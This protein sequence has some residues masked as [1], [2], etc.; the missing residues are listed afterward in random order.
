[1][2]Y[3][4]EITGKN[5]GFLGSG[6]ATHPREVVRQSIEYVKLKKMGSS[7]NKYT[8]YV[9][10][11]HGEAWKFKAYKNV[12]DGKYIVKE[13]QKTT[14]TKSDMVVINKGAPLSDVIDDNDR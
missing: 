10:N 14:L 12:K 11:E 7:L 8:I 9:V 1:M 5:F 3:Y 4:V 2:R 13:L 6:R